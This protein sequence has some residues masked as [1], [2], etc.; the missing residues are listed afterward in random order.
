[1]FGPGVE[2]HR[3]QPLRRDAGR[4][5]VELQLADRYPHAVGAQV[6]QAQDAPAVGDA[7]EP[8][9]FDRPITQ[10]LFDMP[11]SLDRQVHAAWTAEDVAE[12]QASLADGGVVHDRH[13]PRRIGHDRA[14]KQRLVMV[15]Q[16]D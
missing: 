14:V 16:I 3:Q 6:T 5:G 1:L 4:Y 15:E 9:V 12:L 8:H 10:H 2:I 13:E 11:A 7:D